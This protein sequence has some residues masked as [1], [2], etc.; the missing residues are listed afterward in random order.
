MEEED[1]KFVTTKQGV[2]LC[3]EI[4][5][6][7]GAPVIALVNGWTEQ[8]AAWRTEFIDGLVKGGFRVLRFDN[9]D[10]GYSQSF[11]SHN[12]LQ[13]FCRFA[14]LLFTFFYVPPY[15]LWDMAD[16]LHGLLECL[17]I[18][19]PVHVFGFSM[20][21]CISQCFALKYPKQTASLT[22]FGTWWGTAI[23][24]PSAA[25]IIRSV[26]PKS[27]TTKDIV[28]AVLPIHVL[29]E[30]PA[31]PT[32]ETALKKRVAFLV[33]RAKAAASP[34]D[35]YI[36]QFLAL[37]AN[38]GANPTQLKGITCPTLVLV[39]CSDRMVLPE[40]SDVLIANI[41]HAKSKKYEGIGHSFPPIHGDHDG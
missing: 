38:N 19:T 8:Q 14:T 9:R 6:P 1:P 30:S 32:E 24:N 10:I 2:K 26:K 37:Y 36:R 20:G 21:G 11:E 29:M 23:D 5:G 16:D 40:N 35:G 27:N 34:P 13:H 22:L 39:G 28:E 4:S 3:Y 15:T 31:F 17:D 33:T 7:D 18:K 41:P 25:A 12:S